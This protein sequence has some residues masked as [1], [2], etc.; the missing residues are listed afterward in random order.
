ME[1]FTTVSYFLHLLTMAPTLVHLNLDAPGNAFETLFR[2]IDI[3]KYVPHLV[4]EFLSYFQLS[5]KLSLWVVLILRAL[6]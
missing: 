1:K 4:F 5:E 3:S 2:L 6:Q